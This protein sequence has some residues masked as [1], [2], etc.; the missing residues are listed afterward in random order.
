MINFF[1]SFVN[2]FSAHTFLPLPYFEDEGDKY[3]MAFVPLIG[4]II[5][6]L[7]Y[8]WSMLSWYRL[9]NDVVEALGMILI[10]IIVTGGR[11]AL[12]F[13]AYIDSIPTY[14]YRFRSWSESRD[15][16]V[17]RF[18]LVII[19]WTIA[20]ANTYD[21]IFP[22]VLFGFIASRITLGLLSSIF[23]ENSNQSRVTIVLL[24]AELAYL[25]YYVVDEYENLTICPILV[26][27]ILFLLFI[28]S[29]RRSTAENLELLEDDYVVSFETAWI[30]SVAIVSLIRSIG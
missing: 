29:F 10:V 14:K 30:I 18:L 25:I 26:S 15:R 8:W 21:Y 9:Y 5:Y 12:G 1:K 22:L 28:N 7:L 13:I 11:Q 27:V 23:N 16:G 17:L 19:L 20:M 3:K 6:H 24:I 2:A 4:V